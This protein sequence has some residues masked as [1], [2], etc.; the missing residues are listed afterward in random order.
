MLTSYTHEILAYRSKANLRCSAYMQVRRRDKKVS[1]SSSSLRNCS[2]VHSQVHNCIRC[3][4]HL[5]LIKF[6]LRALFKSDIRLHYW[7][8]ILYYTRMRYRIP[9]EITFICGEKKQHYLKDRKGCFILIENNIKKDN[10]KEPGGDKRVSYI[11]KTWT[12]DFKKNPKLY[13]CFQCVSK[14]VKYLLNKNHQVFSPLHLGAVGRP[15]KWLL[16]HMATFT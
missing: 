1:D 5:D 9:M 14:C 13:N 8:T 11:D 4:L 6:N 7:E 16:K 15:D 10:S 3:L 2:S 12:Q